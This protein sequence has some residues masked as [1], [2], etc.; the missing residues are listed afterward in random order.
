MRAPEPLP[1]DLAAALDV[2]GHTIRYF[3]DVGSTNDVA[4]AMASAGAPA[5]TVVVADHQTAGRGRRGRQWF[6]PPGAGLY[7][8]IV[9]RPAGPPALLPLVTLSAGVAAAKAIT[10]TTALP[11]ELKWPN[12]LVVGRPWKKLGGL[13]CET[14]AV[15]A[16]IDAVVVG[17][18]VNVRR[19]AYPR[20]IAERATSIELELSRTIDRGALL[21][22][23]LTQAAEAHAAL[24]MGDAPAI[25][26]E[27]RRFGRAGLGGA[28]V[29]W[30]DAEGDH[31]GRARDIDEAGALVVDGGAGVERL[32]AGE[33]IW[34]QLA[35]D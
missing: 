13:L 9:W 26:A 22:A 21:T 18:G 28:L 29:R 30:A 4:L 11:V 5:R 35:G 17:I 1:D 19:V 7:V 2:P 24:V 34:E 14:A 27:W 25:V 16:Q 32:V 33:V 31:R 12:D 15:G 20:D 23:I 6:S 8:S 10:A 3:A